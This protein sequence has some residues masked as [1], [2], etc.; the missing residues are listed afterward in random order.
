MG[1]GI[2]MTGHGMAKV[3]NGLY[4]PILFVISAEIVTIYGRVKIHA[5]Y[6]GATTTPPT[7][8]QTS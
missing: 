7:P 1:V 3:S 2:D 4:P 8:I 5:R 6:K